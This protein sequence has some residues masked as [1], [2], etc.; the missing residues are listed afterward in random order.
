MKYVLTAIT[1]LVSTLFATSIGGWE[2]IRFSGTD[3]SNQVFLRTE[4]SQSAVN[5]SKLLYDPGSGIAEYDL[6]LFDPAINTWQGTLPG[7]GTRRYLGLK[8]QVG[9]SAVDV[10]P[11]KYTGTANLPALSQFTKINDDPANDQ[12][13]ANLDIVAE[14]FSFSDTKFYAAIQN[15]GGGFP[16]S[17]GTLG[18]IYSYMVA[19]ADPT[20]DPDDPDTIVWAFN[21]MNVTFLYTPGLYKIQNGNLDRIAS[22][23][24]QVL[25]GSNLL[26]MSC[27]RADLMADPDFAA[28]FDPANPALGMVTIISSTTIAQNTT[29]MDTSPGGRI[30]PSAL[31]VDPETQLPVVGEPSLVVTPDDVFFQAQ[32]LHPQ[33]RFP[34][35]AMI[36]IE[37]GSALHS[38]W[39][40]Q[41]DYSQS[42]TFRTQNLLADL[43]EYDESNMRTWFRPGASYFIGN[44]HPF[45]Y[46][47]GL[48]PPTN[49]QLEV[50]ATDLIVSWDPLTTSPLGIT[51]TPDAFLVQVSATPGFETFQDFGTSQ[52]QLSI[53]LQQLGDRRFVRVI[54]VKEVP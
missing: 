27:D 42:V 22:I 9:G 54:A 38:L 48:D 36:Q 33:G 18:P 45:S 19:M 31:F 37:T 43:L 6:G 44:W 40:Q 16:Y 34:L 10:I 20:S 24:Y 46:V 41:R 51:V 29:V 8:K 5:T 11:V 52:A 23:E 1:C 17:G 39:E 4:I 15:R 3:P 35:E 13:T 53:P 7:Q 21:Y 12:A 50:T 2:N 32:Y 26:V 14:Y 30:Y 25:S 47:R 28:W 49:V